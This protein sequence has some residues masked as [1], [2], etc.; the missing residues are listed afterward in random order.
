MGKSKEISQDLRQQIVNFHES[1]L[2]LREISK[3]LTVPRSSVQTIIHKYKNHGTT[4][5]LNRSGRRRVLT[6]SDEDMLVQQV[7]MHP[8]TTV[9]ELVKIL[10]AIGTKIS[11]ST[12]KRVLHRHNLKYCYDESDGTGPKAAEDGDRE[13][14]KDQEN[15]CVQKKEESP[16]SI[17]PERLSLKEED[18]L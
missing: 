6:P 11:S 12:V 2:S 8:R 7:K 9:K 1:G 14:G 13:D 15:M 16:L 17:K 18:A 3:R 5:P 4:Q 10:E